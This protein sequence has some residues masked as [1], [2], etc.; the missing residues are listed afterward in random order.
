MS[1]EAMA[2]GPASMLRASS[3]VTYVAVACGC[4]A[5]LAAAA[6]GSASLAGALM[7]LAVIADTL[8]GRF[9]RRFP[10]TPAQAAFG[11][12]IDSL[13]DAINS[14]LVPV[15]VLGT[16]AFRAPSVAAV[17]WAAVACGFTV[18]AI[19]RLGYYN[20]THAETSGFVG[21]PT[22]VASLVVA[23]ALIWRPGAVASALVLAGC[24]GAMLAPVRIPRPGPRG[25]ALFCAWAL[26]LVVL[27]ATE[28]RQQ[29]AK[30][31]T[32][33]SDQIAL[34]PAFW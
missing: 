34:S 18:A 3:A 10:H 21:V 33:Q 22:P 32:Q 13:A 23:T 1:A 7:A 15:V 28:T 24:A 16:L 29:R 4:G 11:V 2:R 5:A 26:L 12:Q 6:W 19:T 27:H 14:G 31:W 17:A 8:D 25:L 9:A 20:L 30:G